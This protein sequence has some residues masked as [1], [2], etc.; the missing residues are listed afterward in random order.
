MT[1]NHPECREPQAAK[2]RWS[3]AK[4][5]SHL[6][7]IAISAFVLTALVAKWSPVQAQEAKAE[8]KK[9]VVAPNTNK[10]KLKTPPVPSS[11]AIPGAGSKVDALALA[12][13][14]D[15][16]VNRELAANK[17]PVS[18]QADD[19]EFLRR[20]YLDLV[21]VIPPAEKVVAFLNSTD[22]NKR[23]KVIDELLADPRFGASMAELWSGLML[24][25]ESNNRR[26]D[27]TPL[28]KWLADSFNNNMPLDK[29]VYEL[30]TSTG[31]QDKNGAVT[32][33]I[34]NPTVDK[35]CPVP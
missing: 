17:I 31:D 14:I 7:T 9:A 21:G 32:Y 18:P 29:L 2:S 19:A 10:Q 35:M 23:T 27:H 8:Q 1:K 11:R 3:W 15:Q 24:P 20:V 28:Q 5:G 13:I 25:R 4:A 30:V 6:T 22:K 33:F 26:L 34:G 16:E 12:K